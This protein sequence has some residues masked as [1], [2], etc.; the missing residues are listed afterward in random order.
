MQ[1]RIGDILIEKRLLTKEQLDHAL[2]LKIA[3]TKKLGEIFVELGYLT[4]KEVVENLYTQIYE[5]IKGVIEPLA[6][7][8]LLIAELYEV[9]ASLIP[10]KRDFFLA[11]KSEEIAHAEH[12]K[13]MICMVYARPH[14]FEVGLAITPASVNTVIGGAKTNLAK[15]KNR[16]IPRDKVIIILKD[17]EKSLIEA[18]FFDILKTSDSEYNEL[19]RKVKTDTVNHRKLLETI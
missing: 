18:R 10:E 16:E 1:T 13:D 6:D 5:R 15:I 4:G 17:M 12:I 3:S 9:C 8:E 11:L 19:A 2:K 7:L 14:L